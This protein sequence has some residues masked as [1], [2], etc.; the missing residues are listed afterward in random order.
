MQTLVVE[1]QRLL[2]ERL[3]TSP[4]VRFNRAGS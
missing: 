2:D 1:W 3:K 4:P